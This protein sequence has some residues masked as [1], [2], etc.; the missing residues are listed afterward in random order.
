MEVTVYGP[1]RAATGGKRVDV[2]F[3]GGTVAEA[4]EA[5]IEAYPRTKP[6]LVDDDGAFESSVRVS[7]DG[8]SAALEDTCSAD[9]TIGVHP[10]MRGG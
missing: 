2:E 10:A 6:H 9:A 3:D 1:L 5:L 8:E 4:L 7:I